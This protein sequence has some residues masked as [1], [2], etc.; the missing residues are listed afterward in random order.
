M[1]YFCK[2]PIASHCGACNNMDMITTFTPASRTEWLGLKATLVGGSELPA[3][4]G[5]SKY[6]TPFKLLAIKRGE[7][8]EEMPEIKIEESSIHLPPHERGQL[9]E[10]DAIE[11]IRRLRPHWSVEANPIPGG[12]LFVDEW[13]RICSTPD[14][15]IN[16]GEA[17]VQIKTMAQSV[18]CE[19]WM[20]DGVVTPPLAVAVQ[21]IA[22][23]TLSVAG[24]IA[25]AFVAGY[26]I[27]FH[28]IE[29]P[30]KPALM[31]KARELVK[32]FW[33]RV[34]ENDPYPPDFARDGAVIAQMFRED[35]GSTLDLGADT[36]L[37]ARLQERDE[38]KAREADG[39]E[40]AKIRKEI[41][42]EIVLRLGNAARGRMAD[43][44]LIEAKTVRRKAYEVAATTY[45][46][47]KVKR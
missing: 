13:L 35:D 47:V 39:A 30:L 21:A 33:R 22:D 46:A 42:A 6:V 20:T 1:R 16:G 34:E 12:K 5:V 24:R 10:D 38:L 27:D 11:M 4:F 17:C 44:T 8:V 28:L 36:Y 32:D 40:A 15:F 3:L 9:F 25:G 19:E 14:A 2:P 26:G 41:D 43:G 7:Y 31:V 37:H 29:V 23:A 18:F 45:R